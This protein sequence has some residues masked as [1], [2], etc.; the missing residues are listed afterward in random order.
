MSKVRATLEIQDSAD[1]PQVFDFDDVQVHQERP[2]HPEVDPTTGEVVRFHK[3]P[4]TTTTIVGWKTDRG[5][6]VAGTE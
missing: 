3:D 6:Q 1:P 5:L 4:V 2:A